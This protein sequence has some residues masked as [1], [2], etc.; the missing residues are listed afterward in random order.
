MEK[1]FN[2]VADA[3]L[4]AG[5]S[6]RG[7]VGYAA[8]FGR[9]ARIGDFRESIVPGAF[10]RSLSSGADILALANHEPSQV[11]ARTSA[12]TL[13]LA[14]DSKGLH[15]EIDTL[16][17]T[18]YARDML[19]LV[20]SGNAGGCSFAFTLPPGG[21]HWE[22]RSRSLLD[23]NLHEVSIIAGVPAYGDTSVAARSIADSHAGA[24]AARWRRLII[25]G[26]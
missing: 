13:R 11:L 20:R 4:R 18:S 26:I 2:L 22:G 9:E 24:L 8:V 19:E 6:P 15:F 3:E 17:D 16:P 21:D 14:E 5:S 23:V 1:R 12:T 10:R 7:L 25:A